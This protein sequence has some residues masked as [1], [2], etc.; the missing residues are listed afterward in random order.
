M[1]T[2]PTINDFLDCIRPQLDR[3]IERAH[4]AV[5][6]VEAQA[7]KAGSLQSG[8]TIILIFDE[9]KKEFDSG[10]LTALGELKR[11]VNRTKL[12]RREL[13]QHTYQC[14]MNFAIA[15]KAVTKSDKL[16]TWGPAP[17]IDE[18]LS[19]FNRDLQLALKQFDTGFLDPLEP[20]G[21]NVSTN[22]IAAGSIKTNGDTRRK[23]IFISYRREDSKYQAIRIY[24]AFCK[25]LAPENVF[26]DIDSIA[27][28]DDFVE[29]L[30]SRVNE[31]DILMALIGPNWI[32]ASNPATSRRRLDD[33]NDFVRI[34]IRKALSRAVPVVPVLID[35]ARMPDPDHL[36][37]D[38]KALA[39]RQAEIV[40]FRT[41]T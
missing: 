5:A 31:C 25:E 39:R 10:I 24:D 34:E 37:D 19:M 40:E 8:R 28:G 22:S 35:G 14:L 41:S 1:F 26:L 15:A 18:K 16:K 33:P 27:P 36:P 4:K 12:D 2:E 21:S 32:T 17:V 7:A 11:A 29:T 3:A 6:Q 23:R 9:V 30:E 20:A 13:R 38:L